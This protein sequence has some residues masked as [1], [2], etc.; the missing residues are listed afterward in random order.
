MRTV[1]R[2][3]SASGLDVA[4][5]CE[6][7]FA[8][9]AVDQE[10]GADAVAGTERHR[11]I[12][13]FADA[14]NETHNVAE[15]RERALAQL[16]PG[17]SWVKACRGIDLDAQVR[18]H[19]GGPVAASI[20]HG[21][22][23]AFNPETREVA[24]LGT[25][26]QRTY[27]H[28]E[29]WV[30]GTYDWLMFAPLGS[31]P[32]LVDFKG[33]MRATP[34]QRNLQTAFYASCIAKVHGFSRMRVEL[35]YIDED[36]SVSTDAAELDEWDFEGTFE[37]VSAIVGNV[38]EARAAIAAGQ[39]APQRVGSW[40]SFCPSL[41]VCPAQIN[42]MVALLEEGDRV[43]VSTVGIDPF[44]AGKLWVRVEGVIDLAERLKASL[45]ERAITDGQL[46]LPGGERL[47]AVPTSRVSINVD[48][49]LPLLRGIV[50]DRAESLVEVDRSISPGTIDRLVRE[51]A[52]AEGSKIKVVGERIW[53]ELA[54]AV[55][56]SSFVQLRVK[57]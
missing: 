50:G 44:M 16:T 22:A 40:C 24:E 21:Q 42:A 33:S 45:R 43:A 23:Y 49:A 2:R 11:F 20:A 31:I 56:Q 41:R 1:Y 10:S 35:R 13:F 34:A 30:C 12:D 54:P 32:T 48:A 17:G 8:L 5:K 38:N 9:P 57:K 18:L 39:Q 36:G 37:T 47:V 27:R 19:G 3:V 52:A 26:Q 29:P 28:E 6:S 51:V 15:A 46:T 14:W 53:K 25:M 7:S 55:R 4:A